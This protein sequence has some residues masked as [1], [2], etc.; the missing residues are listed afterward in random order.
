MFYKIHFVATIV[1]FDWFR[2]VLRDKVLNYELDHFPV[3]PELD[4]DQS[5]HQWFCNINNNR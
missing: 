5:L 1:F 2:I 3:L 4:V